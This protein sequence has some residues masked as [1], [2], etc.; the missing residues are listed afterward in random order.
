MVRMQF[1]LGVLAQMSLTFAPGLCLNGILTHPCEPEHEE[2]TPCHHETDCSSDPCNT[3][4]VRPE[5]ATRYDVVQALIVPCPLPTPCIEHAPSPPIEPLLF[6][7][8]PPGC[9]LAALRC[10]VLLI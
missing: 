3:V 2:K 10:V 6:D 4:F 7:S 9:D 8:S 5:A 1:M